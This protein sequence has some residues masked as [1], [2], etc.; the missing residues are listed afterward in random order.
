MT[1]EQVQ[2]QP[3]AAQDLQPRIVVQTG[4][5][6]PISAAAWTPDGKF[7]VTGSSDGQILV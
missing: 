5:A 4:H 6:A 3:V 2:A 1:P 7:L